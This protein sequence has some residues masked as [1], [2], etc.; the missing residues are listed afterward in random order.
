MIVSRRIMLSEAVALISLNP[1]CTPM[2]ATQKLLAELKRSSQLEPWA[3]TWGPSERWAAVARGKSAIPIPVDCFEYV[4]FS[5]FEENVIS[6][7]T[8]LVRPGAIHD[9]SRVE[10]AHGVHLNKDVV[11]A[12]WPNSIERFALI[13]DNKAVRRKDY[14]GRRGEYDWEACLIEAARYIHIEGTNISQAQLLSH[15]LAWFGDDAPSES[16]LKDHVSPLYREL[17]R[18]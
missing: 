9:E 7:P 15:L 14:R 10:Y 5:R 6:W 13:E 17:K 12:L 18:A 1:S 4:D 2:L 11:E 3:E 16:T 8:Y